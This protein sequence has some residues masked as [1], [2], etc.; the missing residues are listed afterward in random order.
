M[1][2]FLWSLFLE[3]RLGTLA[4]LPLGREFVI[5][6]CMQTH[7]DGGSQADQNPRV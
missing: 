7:V 5:G 3:D 6:M 2:S 4:R 1:Q